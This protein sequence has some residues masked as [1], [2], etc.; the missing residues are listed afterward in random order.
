MHVRK[1][2]ASP[3][4]SGAESEAQ[5]VGI[6]KQSLRDPNNSQTFATNLVIPPSWL[7]RPSTARCPRFNWLSSGASDP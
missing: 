4:E 3:L 5:P 7:A 1:S 6:V 2:N